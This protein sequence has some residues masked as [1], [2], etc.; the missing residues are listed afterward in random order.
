MPQQ[1]PPAGA[2]GPADHPDGAAP[3]PD[4]PERVVE[5][6]GEHDLSTVRP[7]PAASSTS[8]TGPRCRRPPGAG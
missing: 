4:L 1:Q 3:P 7:S 5:I 6:Y 2:A 8:A